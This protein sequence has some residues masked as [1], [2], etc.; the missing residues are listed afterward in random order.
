[1]TS[2]HPVD[3]SLC[4]CTFRRPTLLARLLSA[5]AEHDYG[6]LHGEFV[7]VDNDAAGSGLP[8]IAQWRGLLPFPSKVVQVAEPN[9]AR[10]RNA[11]VQ[12]AQGEWIVIIDD[13]EWPAP[14]WLTGLVCAQSRYGADAV[15]GPVIPHYAEDVP[16]WIRRGNFFG[17]RRH[18]GG[19]VLRGSQTYTSNVLIRRS[20]LAGIP[21][22]FDQDFG[23]TGGSDAM[24]FWD[25]EQRGARLVWCQ[26][27]TVHE[28]VPRSRANFPWLLRRAYSGGQ[29]FAR[30]ETARL[31]GRWR[32]TRAL[33]LG[34]RAIAQLVA[35]S[36]FSLAWLPLSRVKSVHW[37]RKAGAQLGKLTGLWGARYGAYDQHV[38]RRAN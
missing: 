15:F 37:M 18:A 3:F 16:A 4:V 24:L 1:M 5:L 19:E 22:P 26:E 17:P 12:A 35:A 36:L 32:R 11:G 9:I 28:I 27:A 14:G 7:F 23:L 13:D 8:V 2:D 10:A 25:M 20:A 6:D 30:L 29:I 21:G 33:Q 34:G 38:K 31:A